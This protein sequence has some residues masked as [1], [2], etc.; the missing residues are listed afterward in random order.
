LGDRHSHGAENTVK[1]YL[2]IH[3]Y[4]IKPGVFPEFQKIYDVVFGWPYAFCKCGDIDNDAV[5]ELALK[6]L[7]VPCTDNF[8][9]EPLRLEGVPGDVHISLPSS[10]MEKLLGKFGDSIIKLPANLFHF[11]V[12]YD[13]LRKDGAYALTIGFGEWFLDYPEIRCKRIYIWYYED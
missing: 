13:G 12:C 10:I 11:G 4:L 3:K 1:Q 8:S 5:V 7:L 9:F 2:E 6:S